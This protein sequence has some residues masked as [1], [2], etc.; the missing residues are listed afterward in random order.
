MDSA[1]AL[2]DLCRERL[3][4]E[5]WIVDDMRRLDL[6]E[7]FAGLIAW[8]S[9]FHLSKGDQPAMFAVF[10][11]HAAPG[12]ALMFTSGPADGEAIGE[13]FGEPLHHASLSPET[14]RALLTRHGF[15]VV[16]FTPEDRTCGGRSV[17]L[18]RNATVT[19]ADAGA[20]RTP[21]DGDEATE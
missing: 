9:F 19:E 21:S 6:K 3:P 18:A 10:A 20:S 16:A 7:H 8:D 2:I 13:L 17:W 12:A 4:L 14:Y 5:R 1:A 11:A 15:E